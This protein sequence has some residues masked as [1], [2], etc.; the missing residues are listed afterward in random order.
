VAAFL[1][2]LREYLAG[3]SRFPSIPTFTRT[4]TLSA[5]AS[6]SPSSSF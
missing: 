2:M 1:P 4:T 3:E 5:F 6:F